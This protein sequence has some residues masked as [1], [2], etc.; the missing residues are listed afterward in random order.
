MSTRRRLLAAAGLVA[1]SFAVSAWALPRAPDRVV[2]HW[3]AAGQPDGTMAKLPGLLAIPAIAAVTVGLLAVVPR[4]DPLREN[5]AAFRRH[6]DWFVVLLAGF[7]AYV[8]ALAVAYNLG[9]PVDPGRLVL[10]AV[11]LLF[12]YV[13]VLLE[14]AERNWFVGIRTPWTL[15]SDEVWRRTHDLGATLFKVAGLVALLGVLVP[16]YAFWLLVGPA[17]AVAVMTTVYSFVVYRRVGDGDPA[18][19]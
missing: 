5:L 6:Y 8:H 17:V 16:E 11:G 14:E 3:N 18:T 15:S 10:P 7:L 12:L 4:I 19:G 13:G 2:T 1:L 9:Y